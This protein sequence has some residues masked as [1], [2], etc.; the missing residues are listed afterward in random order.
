MIF[1]AS[2]ECVSANPAAGLISGTKI[3]N[4]LQQNFHTTP[5]WKTCELYG[6]ALHTLKT[7]QYFPLQVHYTNTF[8]K[9]LWL[10]ATFSV[11]TSGGEPHLMYMFEDNS[12]RQKAEHLLELSNQKLGGLVRSLEQSKR[13]S[14]LLRRMGELLQ[15]CR[16]MEE[17]YAVI[18]EFGAQL[19][20]GLA[21][22]VYL[23]SADSARLAA[24]WGGSLFS[25]NH[26]LLDDCWALRRNQAHIVK[27]GQP[28]LKCHHL[29]RA[30]S[31]SY[32]DIP[33]NIQGELLG[34]LHIEST[35]SAAPGA[36][37]EDLAQSLAENLA[38]S[39]SNIKLRQTLEYQS[40]RDP[41]TG[42]FNRRYMEETLRR[43]LNR[44]ARKK[45]A[46]CVIM[47]DIDHFKKF[48][49]SFGH[50]A[51]DLVLTHLSDLMQGQVRGEDVVCRM[52]GEEF[53]M[54]LPDATLEVGLQRAEA[55]RA[56][57]NAQSLEY[58]AHALGNVTVSMGV[59]V[60][61][62]HGSSG[63]EILEQADKA[64][65]RAKH[66]GRDRVEVAE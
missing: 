50:A 24:A 2:G 22:A 17:A 11:F 13:N 7:G 10:N 36:E 58:N 27:T 55:I 66:R 59:S 16:Q 9:E 41:L 1:K 31:G 49:D 60:Y 35:L 20:P 14:D 30:F 15:L 19:F 38:L 32:M 54:I 18:E 42:V 61:P 34:L 29:G 65:Y 52:G 39:L 3:E 47:L 25:E 5:S 56:A 48:N 51:G 63:S 40:V 6:A 4:L 8:G 28:G 43:E 64:M 45:I 21:G 23:K 44:A 57:V 12:D 53:V 26:F 33:M 37:A 46:I 62:D